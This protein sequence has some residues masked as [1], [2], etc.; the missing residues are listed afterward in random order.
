MSD[1]EQKYQKLASAIYLITSFFGNEEPLKWRLRGLSADLVSDGAKDKLT[2]AR[3]IVSLFGV[4]RA[5]GLVSEINHDILANELGKLSAEAGNVQTMLSTPTVALPMASAPVSA[6]PTPVSAPIQKAAEPVIH[7]QPEE[8][9]S[10][11]VKDMLP[12]VEDIKAK[13]PVERLQTLKE[14][15]A[16]SVKKNSRQSVI[17]GLLKRKK[18][19]MIKD[20][21]PLISGCSE[22][23]IQRELSEMVTAGILK[24]MGEKRWTRYT[25]AQ[26][27]TH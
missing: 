17:I 1:T 2:A 6:A 15:G 22:K 8:S 19:I 27:D 7:S 4:A 9:K 5:A 26:A 11:A 23:T 14:F 21:S 3:D 13:V 25:L 18:E 12:S 24:K 10:E 20:V 16:V